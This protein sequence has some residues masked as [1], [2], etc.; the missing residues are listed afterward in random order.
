MKGLGCVFSAAQHFLKRIMADTEEQNSEVRACWQ[1]LCSRPAIRLPCFLHHMPSMS[2]NIC[3]LS[4]QFLSEGYNFCHMGTVHQTSPNR[5]GVVWLCTWARDEGGIW[6]CGTQWP[7]M[8]RDFL[9]TALAE[10]QEFK[11]GKKVNVSLHHWKKL[12]TVD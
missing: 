7:Q 6:G 2:G 1:S 8:G 3:S 12:L 11:K 5:Q 4:C 9:E 10:T